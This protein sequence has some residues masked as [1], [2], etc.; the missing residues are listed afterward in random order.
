[1]LLLFLFLTARLERQYDAMRCVNVT[2][3]RMC[4]IRIYYNKM[5]AKPSM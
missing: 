3:L 1:M 5:V 2:M 4:S